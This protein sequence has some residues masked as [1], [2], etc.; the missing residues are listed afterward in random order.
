MNIYCCGLI[1]ELYV[2]IGSSIDHYLFIWCLNNSSV[3]RDREE[4][5][6]TRAW[7]LVKHIEDAAV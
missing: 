2:C 1:V 7:G 6:G 5:A 3:L 4:I